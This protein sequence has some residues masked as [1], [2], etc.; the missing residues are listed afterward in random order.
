MRLPLLIGDLLAHAGDTAGA[1]RAY[2]T[3]ITRWRSAD[4]PDVA[5]ARARLAT[6]RRTP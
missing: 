5:T 4:V 2:E 1:I 3:M 6:L